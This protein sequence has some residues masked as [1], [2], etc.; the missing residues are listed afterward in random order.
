MK[1][2]VRKYCL[3][4]HASCLQESPQTSASSTL[5]I[6]DREMH[7]RFDIKVGFKM[8]CFI[9]CLLL[10]IILVSIA[11]QGNGSMEAD[12]VVSLPGQP[13]VNFSMFAGYVTVDQDHGRAQFYYFV[14][15]AEEPEEKPLV[16][17]L[18]GGTHRSIETRSI[19]PEVRIHR[20]INCGCGSQGLVVHQ[21]RLDLRR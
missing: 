12:R 10:L 5:A 19:S 1:G 21:L 16:I 6:K 17:W 15:A 18:T 13:P 20:L 4:L 8:N 3:Y 9:V 7:R 14:E 11:A 2:N